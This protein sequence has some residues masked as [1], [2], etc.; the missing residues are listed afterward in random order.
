MKDAFLQVEDGIKRARR[1]EM[2]ESAILLSLGAC[3]AAILVI[4]FVIF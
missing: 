2:L 1:K 3:L 4:K